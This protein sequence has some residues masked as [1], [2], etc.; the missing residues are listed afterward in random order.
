M[1]ETFLKNVSLRDMWNPRALFHY[2][3]CRLKVL[4]ITDPQ[5]IQVQFSKDWIIFS[6]VFS[7][8]LKAI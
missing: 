7:L 8:F 4:P 5:T 2:I 3:D 6:D 1:T